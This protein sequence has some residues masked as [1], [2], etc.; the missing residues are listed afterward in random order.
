MADEAIRLFSRELSWIEFNARVL[1]EA[2]RPEVPL[3]E[4]LRFLTIVS[5]NF[6]EFFMVRVASLKEECLRAPE[7][8]DC[9]G[10]TVREQLARLSARVHELVDLQFR[11]LREDIL[12]GLQREGLE[13]VPPAK[14][15]TAQLR[16]L[17][18][19]FMGEVFPLL[20]P[21]RANPDGEIPSIGN[22]RLHAAFLLRGNIAMPTGPLADFLETTGI[23]P[24]QDGLESESPRPPLAIVQIP[25]SI[26]RVV[27]L[28]GAEGDRRRFTLLD[29]VVR[30]FGQR[31]F[32][33]FSI[34]ESLLF[35]VARDADRA[36]DEERDDDFIAA[37][38]E[39]LASRL[40]SVP[41]RLMCA[42]E[43]PAILETLKESMGLAMTTTCTTCRGP[44]PFRPWWNSPT[45]KASIGSG[46]P[47]GG[48]FGPWTFPR[49][50]PSGTSSSAATC[51]STCRT[52][53]TSRY[54]AS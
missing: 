40:S 36:V 30:S 23:L 44:W 42:G 15:D 13:Y 50:D 12:P 52:N 5:S 6:D 49:R 14:Y 4:R 46:T 37:I 3:L 21:L 53:P 22:L 43:S 33:G 34:V 10:S 38:Q 7:A 8:R 19:F 2:L 28:S 26:P 48:P 18:S 41:V 11:C 51:S 54:S 47:S 32:P 16:F 27:W 20:T 17:D 39:V 31:L 9:T 24:R 1:D 45:P 29:D 25:A 35:K